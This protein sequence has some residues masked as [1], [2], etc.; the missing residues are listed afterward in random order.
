MED[1]EYGTTVPS[2]LSCANVVPLKHRISMRPT[3]GSDFCRSD[4]K[5]EFGIF[6]V[7]PYSL[8]YSIMVTGYIHIYG[9]P[10][11]TSTSTSTWKVA[12]YLHNY[13]LL[14]SEI[15]CCFLSASAS[16]IQLCNLEILI[17]NM[18]AL[19]LVWGLTLNIWITE[20][21]NQTTGFREWCISGLKRACYKFEMLLTAVAQPRRN[22]QLFMFYAIIYCI[23][24]PH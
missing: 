6:C 23:A 5:S 24:P 4:A 18:V 16:Q 21:S 13:L 22:L 7:S 14:L 15:N 9:R 3:S 17:R 2:C 12:Y 10:R 19:P 8:H 20:V 11:C 1:E